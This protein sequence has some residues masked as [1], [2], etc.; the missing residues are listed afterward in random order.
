MMPKASLYSRCSAFV[1]VAV[2]LC[3]FY[4]RA[5]RFEK[6]AYDDMY[7]RNL[8]KKGL[9]SN[10]F[11][12]SYT[13]IYTNPLTGVSGQ[14][15]HFSGE[16]SL[17]HIRD[18]ES[19]VPVNVDDYVDRIP[20]VVTYTSDNHW[21]ETDSHLPTLLDQFDNVVI[22]TLGLKNKTISEALGKYGSKI[23]FIKFDRSK[24]PSHLHNL[25]NYAFK[26]AI[27]ADAVMRFGWCLFLDASVFLRGDVM[28]GLRDSMFNKEET[29]R[30]CFKY[31]IQDAWL[32]IFASTRENLYDY[33]PVPQDDF[34]KFNRFKAVS[35][36]QSGGFSVLPTQEC[37]NNFVKPVLMCSL[38]KD[39]IDLP[40]S[41][42]TGKNRHR[43]DQSIAHTLV[44][45]M[46]HFH[47]VQEHESV[48]QKYATPRQEV[49]A[50]VCR[51]SR[52][53]PTETR[54]ELCAEINGP[55][56]K[57][58]SKEHCT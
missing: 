31:V 20:Q 37:L 44:G 57:H 22:Y 41:S 42:L 19:I 32:D 29:N 26:G 39:C 54:K 5:T 3:M 47:T 58:I 50:V 2:L 43:Y 30:V 12:T 55:I 34:E 24:Y 8:F 27:W 1:C 13:Y 38:F 40:G 16:N 18:I 35:Q 48:P 15:M 49:A 53:C 33:F 36:Q 45:N 52:G 6:R 46:Y 4:R 28:A 11:P 10:D 17:K 56:P 23:Q 9:I 25:K 51:A 14:A 7:S 21:S